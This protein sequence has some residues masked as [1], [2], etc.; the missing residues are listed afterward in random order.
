MGALILRALSP[1]KL[2][3]GRAGPAGPGFAIYEQIVNYLFPNGKLYAPG[4]APIIHI[5]FIKGLQFI[6]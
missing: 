1:S 4:Q 3:A 5:L 6:H 2:R